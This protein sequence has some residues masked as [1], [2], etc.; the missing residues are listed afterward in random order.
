MKRGAAWIVA[1][2]ALAATV[3]CR[4]SLEGK[5]ISGP[6]SDA[7]SGIIY[8]LTQPSFTIDVKDRADNKDAEPVYD[9]KTASAPDPQKRFSVRLQGGTITRDVLSLKLQP[10]GT[11]TSLGATSESQIPQLVT[12][13][14]SLAA[15]ALSFGTT[16]V[17]ALAVLSRPPEYQ[18]FDAAL[19][20]ALCAGDINR[21]DFSNMRCAA[22]KLL[23]DDP[24]EPQPD[25][26]CAGSDSR[27]P[28][29]ILI[30][31]PAP[32]VLSLPIPA[33][34]L[35]DLFNLTGRLIDGIES[36]L[37]EK[38][39]QI[40]PDSQLSRLAQEVGEIHQ[41]LQKLRA[42]EVELASRLGTAP[43]HAALTPPDPSR[44][45]P[46]NIRRNLIRL[47]STEIENLHKAEADRAQATTA[48][49][50]ATLAFR[51]AEAKG[52]D[53]AKQLADRERQAAASRRQTATVDAES[54]ATFLAGLASIADA[55]SPGLVDQP[56]N[57]RIKDLER[58][59]STSFA[60]GDL[61]T[62]NSARLHEQGLLA[63]YRGILRLRAIRQGLPSPSTPKQQI[64][65]ALADR[66]R[67]AEQLYAKFIGDASARPA[68]ETALKEYQQAV[69]RFLEVDDRLQGSKLRE[70]QQALAKLP[71]PTG[72]TGNE[73][74]AYRDYR[75]ELDRV[76]DRINSRIGSAI[77]PKTPEKLP[78]GTQVT[79]TFDQVPA[80]VLGQKTQ[81]TDGDEELLLLAEM[82]IK[83]GG[84][85][86]I[87][88]RTR[89]SPPGTA[90]RLDCGSDPFGASVSARQG[91]PLSQG[92]TLAA[93]R[94]VASGMHVRRLTLADIE[95]TSFNPQG[96][97]V[98]VPVPYDV[99]A[100]LVGP[101]GD[102]VLKAASLSLPADDEFLDVGFKGSL[103]RS[104][105]LSIALNPNGSVAEYKLDSVQKVSD[106]VQNVADATKDITDTLV[107]I[108]KAQP[109]AVNPVDTEN[110]Q[111]RLEILNL[112]LK[113]NLR[114]L[115]EG[116]DLPFPD[117]FES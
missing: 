42:L 67:R 97:L 57:D 86:S 29:A 116:R 44:F 75:E 112:M 99:V 22:R 101:S 115:Q 9:L 98:Q 84:K 90:D 60:K 111:L 36:K 37:W 70:Q 15:S 52:D 65:T 23:G 92:T 40:V 88:F 113:E 83:Y 107:E 69:D 103:F 14:G 94:R 106:T 51:E 27:C 61:A 64:A 48:E 13:L 117:L 79:R 59:I 11:L 21:Q 72:P 71:N 30:P 8:Y 108:Q 18:S 80:C 17:G 12:A 7:R 2:L 78:R 53:A 45:P 46:T 91:R 95:D 114:A 68:F 62:Q 3:G 76:L 100:V 81:L 66:K 43:R 50:L 56:F 55:A 77:D 20:K 105:E 19:Q 28:Q 6:G 73:S 24:K 10:N 34:A 89:S 1:T 82:W 87:V 35:Q 96:V 109:A 58:K 41:P 39:S 5:K 32:E 26:S 104:Q 47:I 31:P 4:A 33:L 38:L 85:E 74:K 16:G 54:A 25:L 63:M 110:S 93:M 102:R 49:S